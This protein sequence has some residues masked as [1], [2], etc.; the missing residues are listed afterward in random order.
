[1][2]WSKPVSLDDVKLIKNVFGVTVNDVLVSAL[3][4]AFRYGFSHGAHTTTSPTRGTHNP[5][6]TRVGSRSYLLETDQLLEKD[7]LTAIPGTSPNVVLRSSF[8]VLRSS[9][10]ALRSYESWAWQ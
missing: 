4:A 8:F 3:T 1:M 6:L 2:T 7:L 9:F 10:F 5:L